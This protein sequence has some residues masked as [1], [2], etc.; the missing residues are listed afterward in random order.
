MDLGNL[1]RFKEIDSLNAANSSIMASRSEFDPANR[2]ING[3]L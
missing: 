2:A 3:P 1:L